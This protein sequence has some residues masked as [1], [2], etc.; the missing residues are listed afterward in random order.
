MRKLLIVDDEKMIR[1]GLKAIIE[2]E[3]TTFTKVYEASGAD[4]A[5][6][7]LARQ[8]IDLTITDIRMPGINGIQFIKK[9]KKMDIKTNFIILSGYEDF[10][11]AREAIKYGAKDYLLKPVKKNILFKTLRNL[12]RELDEKDSLKNQLDNIHIFK[13]QCYENQLNYIFTAK[14][15]NEYEIKNIL[16]VM[17]IGLFS[18]AFYAAV[19]AASSQSGLILEEINNLNTSK[20]NAVS[21]INKDGHIVMAGKSLRLIEETAGYLKNELKKKITVGVSSEGNGIKD[22]Q[23][24][25]CQAC[26]AVKHRIFVH[27]GYFIGFKEIE[28]LDKNFQVPVK[29]IKKLIEI[30]DTKNVS[31]IKNALDKILDIKVISGYNIKYLEN[32]ARYLSQYMMEYCKSRIPQQFKESMND[33]E[34]LS[35]I[36]NYQSI[37]EYR[38][39]VYDHMLQINRYLHSLEKGIY[40]SKNDIDLAIQFIKENIN[41]D[42]TLQEVADHVYLNYSYF[43][44]LFKERTGSNFVDCLKKLR[45]DKAKELLRIR[46]YKIKDVAEEVGFN[47]P[48][49]FTK[50]FRNVTGI[51]PMEYRNASA[52]DD[53]S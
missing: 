13:T 18:K 47:N 15:I 17:G 43:S 36:Y 23:R 48:K 49:Y 32:T 27:L 8:S 1:I 12:E 3:K 19:F 4:E 9:A 11:Y 33:K 31:E 28:K 7:I 6:D 50:V 2:R 20:S 51:S 30:L 10:Q 5:L 34:K 22:I 14:Q 29:L 53:N 37:D 46:S 26:E 16:D 39:A 38:Q 40:Y 24:A 35:N 44:H 42:L 25:Y 21:F 52:S 41:K 45:I